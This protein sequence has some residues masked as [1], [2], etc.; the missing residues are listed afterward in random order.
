MKRIE[1]ILIKKTIG[2]WPCYVNRKKM[3]WN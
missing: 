2:L 1:V 3:E